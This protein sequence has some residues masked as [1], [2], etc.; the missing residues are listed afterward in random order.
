MAFLLLHS[1]I[2]YVDYCLCF[3]HPG[4]QPLLD[5]AL[6]RCAKARHRCD[7]ATLLRLAR[8]HWLRLHSHGD[9]DNHTAHASN[10]S[11]ASSSASAGSNSHT[12]GSAD[13]ESG[14]DGDIQSV[15][16]HGRPVEVSVALLETRL[17]SLIDRG[18]LL[19]ARGDDGG[20][21]LEYV[22]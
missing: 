22:P 3:P 18:Y 15:Q 19:E 16:W 12:S 7:R 11:S 17:P 20:A 2:S 8:A 1:P 5:A 13:S 9:D 21:V 4:I 6:L 10:G 14:R